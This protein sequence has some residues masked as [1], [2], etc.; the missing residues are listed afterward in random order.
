MF[1]R[2]FYF[3]EGSFGDLAKITGSLDKAYLLNRI[4]IDAEIFEE[5]AKKKHNATYIAEYFFD[6]YWWTTINV[7][8]EK[9]TLM[10]WTD[11]KKLQKHLNELVK[12]RLLARVKKINKEGVERIF[13]RVLEPNVRT[14]IA[15]LKGEFL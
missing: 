11:D 5:E 10:H 7:N 15:K 6:Y 13:Y 1:E 3:I 8:E 2:M 4:G 9:R 14:R 12:D